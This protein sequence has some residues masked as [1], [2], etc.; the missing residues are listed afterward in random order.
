MGAQAKDDKL[1]AFFT[2]LCTGFAANLRALS[3][4]P[5]EHPETQKKLGSFYQGIEKYLQQRPSLA[6]IFINGEVVV[7]NTPLPELS[8]NLA[9]LIDMLEAMKLQRIIFNRGV[10]Q[11][12]VVQLFQML[13][14]LLKNPSEADLVLAKNQ[15]RLP[16]ILAG[17]LPFEA[18]G[19]MSYEELSG[20]LEAA[21]NS[22]L[23]FSGQLKDLFSGLDGPM[24]QEKVNIA[25]ETTETIHRMTGTGEIP[26]KT[27]IYRRSPD[28]DPYIHAINVCALSM[29]IARQ[30]ELEDGL[31]LDLGL[32]ALLHDIG[33]HLTRKIKMSD[34]AAI[35]LD[36][37]KRQWE[38]PLR[39]AEILM[40]SPE[41][42]DLVPLVAYEHHLHFDGGG[43]PKQ[44]APRDLNLASMIVFIAN[45]YDDLRRNRPERKAYALTDTINWMDKRQGSIFHPIL[46]KEFRA[47]VKRQA[48][49]EI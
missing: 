6:M 48:A 33:L 20:V 23:S 43:Y 28:P 21:R 8:G 42:P 26:I 9:K 29:A 30:M 27:L 14:P 40:A 35:S 36:D 41:L 19:Q 38:H 10:S 22:V 37:K 5:P 7:E 25:K 16:H 34:T 47:L 46:L 39:G 24:G 31:V 18:G 2:T 44:K 32:G 1:K 4:Y 15:D 45:A 3:L 13:V 17:A 49:E 11:E 12:E